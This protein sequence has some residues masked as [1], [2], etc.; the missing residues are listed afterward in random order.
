VKEDSK[1]KQSI[2]DKQIKKMI[3]VPG[4]LVNVVVGE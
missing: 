4:K 3:V 2:M 1:I